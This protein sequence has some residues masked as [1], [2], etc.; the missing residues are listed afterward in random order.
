MILRSRS[1][2][3]AILIMRVRIR[4]NGSGG[5][6]TRGAAARYRRRQIPRRRG[7]GLDGVHQNR[8]SGGRFDPCLGQ[9][10]P[11]VTRDAPSQKTGYGG[12]PLAGHDCHGG[13]AR[14]GSP[15]CGRVGRSVAWARVQLGRVV[16]KSH[17][18][19]GA[20]ALR[21]GAGLQGVR[22]GGATARV[23]GERRIST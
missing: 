11:C 17:G 3:Y 18:Q 16:C 2:R 12:A 7:S 5:K 9:V 20:G 23:A 10:W 6:R 19:A 14:R 8:C 15:A 13:S 22:H 21:C 4:S 1:N